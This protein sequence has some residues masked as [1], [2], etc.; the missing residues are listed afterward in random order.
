MLRQARLLTSLLTAEQHSIHTASVHILAAQHPS[1]DGC[2]RG[3]GTYQI[4]LEFWMCLERLCVLAYQ[5]QIWTLCT[6]DMV[7]IYISTF[8]ISDNDNDR[9]DNY[10]SI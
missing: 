6:C 5:I 2:S 10:R 1:G 4:V 7:E 9:P 8:K 3:T